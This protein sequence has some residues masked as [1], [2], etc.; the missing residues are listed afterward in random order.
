MSA[1]LCPICS[2]PPAPTYTEAWRHETEMRYV[3]GLPSRGARS[4][5]L[6]GMEKVRRQ[7]IVEGL[8]ATLE[9]AV[10]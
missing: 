5:Y 10:T 6:H 9:E 1:C 4:N 3:L 8:K 7:A 2:P